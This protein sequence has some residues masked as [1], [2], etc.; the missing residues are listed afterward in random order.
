MEL[1]E[2]ERA[3]RAAVFFRGSCWHCWPVC[4][5]RYD[6]R[7]AVKHYMCRRIVVAAELLLL[8]LLMQL[9]AGMATQPSQPPCIPYTSGTLSP[10]NIFLLAQRPECVS[11][12]SS[13]VAS[14][15]AVCLP[16]CSL[17]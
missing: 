11:E 12:R 6:G 4:P 5:G 8:L 14:G 2:L 15:T 17:V 16:Q 13:R 1:T 10:L 7:R 3:R 9:L